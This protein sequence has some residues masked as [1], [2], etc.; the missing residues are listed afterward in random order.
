MVSIQKKRFYFNG[1]LLAGILLTAFSLFYNK[2]RE[3]GTPV[4]DSVEVLTHWLGVKN[5]EVREIYKDPQL[6]KVLDSLPLLFKLMD[7][8][9][10]DENVHLYILNQEHQAVYWSTNSVSPNNINIAAFGNEE[11]LVKINNTYHVLKV[12]PLKNGYN[13]VSLL[14]LYKIYPVENAYLKSGFTI[15][16]PV[17]RKV[18]ITSRDDLQTSVSLPVYSETGKV[19]FFIKEDV[20]AKR[21]VWWPVVIIEFLGIVFIFLV[22]NRRLRYALFQGK[23]TQ[24]VLLTSVYALFIEIYVNI[25][26]V[27]SFTGIGNLF[28][29]D[30]YASPLLADS[31]GEL[32]FR[33]QLAHWILRHWVR[34]LLLRYDKNHAVW[35]NLFVSF[36]L[37]A[38]YYFVIFIIASLHHSSIVSFDL[39]RFDQL[40]LG[41]FVGILIINFS[42]GIMFIP[43]TYLKP[44]FFNKT[45]FLVQ[46]LLHIIFVVLGFL[47]GNFDSYSIVITLLAIY[48]LYLYLLIWLTRKREIVAKHRF[49]TSLLLLSAYAFIGAI[50]ILY[51]TNQ[52]KVEMIQHYAIELAS[53]RDYA[54]E[55]DISL[56]VDE[57]REDNFV[58][59]YF[60]NPYLSSFDIDRRI[61]QRYFNKYQGKYNISIHTFNQE[62]VQLKGESVK[63]FYALATSKEQKGVQRISP[64]IYYLSVKPRGEKYMVF[65]EYYDEESLLGYVVMVFTPKTFVSYSAYPELLKSE[66]EHFMHERVS[67]IAYAIYRNRN[68]MSVEGNYSYP[69]R[70]NFP[71]PQSGKF[72]VQNT[73]DYVHTIYS[74]AEK[75]VVVTYKQTGLLSSFSYFSYLLILQMG[76]FYVLSLMTSYG[77]FWATG[78]RIRRNLQLNTL[79]KQI[80][81]SMVSQVLFSLVLVG[82]MTVFFFNVQ[83]NHLHNESLKQR[84]NSVVEALEMM[85]AES[86]SVHSDEEFNNILKNKIKQLSEIFA[87][88]MNA[89]D[90]S[91]RLLYSS[92]SDIFKGGLQSNL[93]NP[94]AYEAL[95]IN[96]FSSFIQDEWIGK[97]KYIAAYLPINDPNGK[98]VG[99]INFPYYGKEKN[100]KN[101]ISFFL[102]SLVNIYVLLILGASMIS[103]WVSKVIVKPLSIITESIKDVELGKK[104]LHIEWKNKDEIGHLVNEYNRMIDV[105]EESAGLLAKSEREGAWREM[106][107]QVAHEIK[108]PL[109]PMKLSIQHLQRALDE[110]R[111][112][113]EEMTRKIASRLIEQIDTLANIATAFSNFA[114]MPIG[115]PQNEDIVPILN[116]VVDLFE[117]SEEVNIFTSIPD[118]RILAFVDKDQMVRVFTNLIKNAVQAIPEDRTG[119]LYVS[120]EESGRHCNIIV[121]DN[122]VGIPP[123]RAKDIFEPNFTTKSS[124]TGLGLAMSKSIVESAGGKIWFESDTEKG[125][126]TFYVQLNTIKS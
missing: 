55:F 95:K 14:T 121:K 70:F 17:L 113:I 49:F 105:L 75:Q 98:L 62:G 81:T 12:Y 80:Q 73:K 84:G 101:D 6:G 94:K 20:L 99:Y 86:F 108:N 8:K 56:I 4:K 115:K 79:Q 63:T 30:S 124:G 61:R 5:E 96:G 1:L 90:L 36:Y 31:L 83:Y 110:G 37:V 82:S 2:Y 122:G 71:L 24:A 116:S 3:S 29:L 19:L 39:N 109:T 40:D 57:L 28:Q 102:M 117:T 13:L 87:I 67:D 88:D 93:M 103:I 123:E 16:A 45:S 42:F 7:S 15:P 46:V 72:I 44:Y 91:G 27:P 11:K 92:Q 33:I 38:S 52:R 59:S 32:F 118:K 76:F 10:T 66:Q 100:I 119:V 47:F 89:Y 120:V 77:N 114:K 50:S 65:I 58:K 125:G 18:M 107:K 51:Y 112:D 104:N 68:L 21:S 9:R 97:L 69:T 41:S 54:E 85:Y 126:T 43:V 35:K 111:D 34:Y 106:A 23:M 26:H 74:I 64:Y 25:L 53:E 48:G 22:V 60:Y 78:R